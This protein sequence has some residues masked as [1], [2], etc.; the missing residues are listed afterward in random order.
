MAGTDSGLDK[1]QCNDSCGVRASAA[2]TQ[3]SDT[4]VMGD[5]ALESYRRSSYRHA[6]AIA[7]GHAFC[8][9]PLTVDGL[10]EE[11]LAGTRAGEEHHEGEGE[12]AQRGFNVGMTGVRG[13]PA[14]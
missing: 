1:R 4:Q 6:L 5:P 9:E 2:A 10:A 3:S 8:D 14:I 11:V 13:G 7:I 12:A